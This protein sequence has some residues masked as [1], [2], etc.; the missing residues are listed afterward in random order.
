MNVKPIREG[1]KNNVAVF[2]VKIASIDAG[3]NAIRFVA[4]EF[5]SP[6][7]YSILA[8][9]RYPVRLGKS[10]FFSGRLEAG[11]M[12]DAIAGLK[13]IAARMNQLAVSRYR[14]VAT[15]AVRESANAGVFLKRVRKETGLDLH[16][17][18]GSEEARCVYRAIREKCPLS[19]Q[20]YVLADLGGGSLE[21]SLCDDSGIL[22]SESHGMGAVRLMETLTDADENTERYS[23]VLAEYTAT[24]QVPRLEY[25]REIAGLIA[26]GGN[27]EALAKLAAS[28]ENKNGVATLR[29]NALQSLIRSLSHLSYA[30]R[31]DK[32][33]LTEDRAD[34]ILPAALVYLRLAEL[35]G[36]KTILVPTI[37]LKEGILFDMIDEMTDYETRST[38]I[39]RK[40]VSGAIAL[41]RRYLF[42]ERHGLQAAK[43]SVSLFDQTVD[44]HGMGEEERNML[45]AAGVVH[46][47][48]MFVSRG[49]HHKHSM[50]LISQ[51]DLPGLTPRQIQ[52]IAHIARYHRKSE[53]S[54][55]HV[56]FLE[57][58][59]EDRTL[60]EKL[61][62]FLR[63]GDA[64]DREHRQ[65]VL[66]VTP[67][68]KRKSL[69]LRLNGKDDLLL[70]RWAVK[71]K[72][73]LFEKAFGLSVTTPEGPS[74]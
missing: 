14:A 31:V 11:A 43:L 54:L 47:I 33:G 55:K 30:Q 69:A 63:I 60:V 59:K 25:K 44:L 15:S 10:V 1:N 9:Q 20:Q 17:I 64:L 39:E 50:Y 61:S 7:S 28:P 32:L 46:D 38:K 21:I 42:D 29:V 73:K 26:T 6:R 36:V 48:G 70:E 13:E 67:V 8:T 57:L 72:S 35:L 52:I 62:A 5:D 2:P 45:L 40:I 53:P 18:N 19:H 4:A 68:V 56:S 65:N 41:G 27:I 3:S 49:R 24:L 37:G 23:R 51:S 74:L 12:S 66:S 34:V 58:P 71:N 22:W 16:T